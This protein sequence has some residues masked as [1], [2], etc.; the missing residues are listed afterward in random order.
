MPYR[1]PCHRSGL[2]SIK[3]TVDFVEATRSRLHLHDPEIAS[4]E[5][6]DQVVRGPVPYRIEVS[7]SNPT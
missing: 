5:P 2:T 6:S 4:Q 3:G 1:V 7:V